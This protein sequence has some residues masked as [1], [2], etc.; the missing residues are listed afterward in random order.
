MTE[1]LRQFS[2]I[3]EIMFLDDFTV[4]FLLLL[5]NY[6]LKQPSLIRIESRLVLMFKKVC[7]QDGNFACKII[8]LPQT[9]FMTEFPSPISAKLAEPT[10]VLDQ[11]TY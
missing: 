2:E 9:Y 7:H 11:K 6:F 1:R 10:N 5:T 4:K 8:N 3:I